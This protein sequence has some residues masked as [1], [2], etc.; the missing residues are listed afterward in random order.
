MALASSSGIASFYRGDTKVFNLTFADASGTAIDISGLK[1]WVTMK[2]NTADLDDAAA[3]QKVITFPA[4]AD[5]VAGIGSITL[6]S[7]ETSVTPGTYYYDFQLVDESLSPP[8][9]T[10]ITSGRVNILQD[11]TLTDAEI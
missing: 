4:D 6:S 9:V 5:S 11:I 2:S 3:I 1:L 8:S 10:T 7:V